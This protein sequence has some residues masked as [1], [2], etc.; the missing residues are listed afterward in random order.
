[1]FYFSFLFFFDC[2]TGILKEENAGCNDFGTEI[3]GLLSDERCICRCTERFPDR[4]ATDDL[5]TEY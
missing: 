1:M 4:V 2:S 3:D 5:G